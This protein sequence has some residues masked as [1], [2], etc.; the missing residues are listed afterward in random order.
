MAKCCFVLVA[1]FSAIL[2]LGVNDAEAQIYFTPGD[3]P[4]SGNVIAGRSNVP[5][6]NPHFV[7]MNDVGEIFN[8]RIAQVEDQVNNRSVESITLMYVDEPG[9]DVTV[10]QGLDENGNADFNLEAPIFIPANSRHSVLVFANLRSISNN[11]NAAK[12]GDQ[13]RFV[14]RTNEGFSA[15]CGDAEVNFCGGGDVTGNLMVVRKSVPTFSR[16][17]LQDPTLRN[18]LN[19]IYSFSVTASE[20]GDISLALIPIAMGLNCPYVGREG[21]F[22]L[23]E[24]SLLED[25]NVLRKGTD[26]DIKGYQDRGMYQEVNSLTVETENAF[27]RL[28]IRFLNER[29]ISAGQRRVYTLRAVS[30]N[31]AGRGTYSVSAYLGESY[32]WQPFT[33]ML[34]M[35]RQFYSPYL[36]TDRDNWTPEYIWSDFSGTDGNGEHHQYAFGDNG[37]PSTDWINGWGLRSIGSELTTQV[38]YCQRDQGQVERGYL[39]LSNMGYWDGY[40]VNPGQQCRTVDFSASSNVSYQIR[41]FDLEIHRLDAEDLDMDDP[42]CNDQNMIY[43]IYFAQNHGM[44]C[45]P[46]SGRYGISEAENI[47][48]LNSGVKFR[49]NT[50]HQE[51]WFGNEN[52]NWFIS[53]GFH[54]EIPIGI[55]QF[56]I[57]F[58]DQSVY[59]LTNDRWI[60]VEDFYQNDRD[61]GTIVGFELHVVVNSMQLDGDIFTAEDNNLVDVRLTSGSYVGGFQF[62]LRVSP[63]LD[64]MPIEFI[65]P[66]GFQLEVGLEE[67]LI[68]I[69]VFSVDMVYID[70][71]DRVIM[72]MR[73]DGSRLEPQE[74]IHFEIENLRLFDRDGN[75]L[76]CNFAGW[77]AVRGMLGDPNVDFC[78]DVADVMAAIRVIHW[79]SWERFILWSTDVNGDNIWSITD[80]MAIVDLAMHE[81][82]FGVRGQDPEPGPFYNGQINRDDPAFEWGLENAQ[83]IRGLQIDLYGDLQNHEVLLNRDRCEGMTMSQSWHDTLGTMFRRVV[84]WSFGNSIQPGNGPLIII[85]GY[86]GQVRVSEPIIVFGSAN[87]I[88]NNQPKTPLEFKLDAAFPNPFNSSTCIAFAL[89]A[90]GKA[91]MAVYDLSG[92]EVTR[93]VNNTI[94]AGV[95]AVTFDGKDLATG[96]Y[97]LRLETPSG[98][99]SQKLI[100]VK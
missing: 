41:S 15:M 22:T 53:A 83:A 34:D 89:P 59:D 24:F 28:D 61:G 95:Y 5:I 90:C 33:G 46:W 92:R 96:V 85:P 44:G 65:P 9:R 6:L 69:L 93:L 55:Y 42:I 74:E 49:V 27:A 84:I 79:G 2:C 30:S 25:D 51:E 66:D 81:G 54:P 20:A 39:N 70:P 31:M 7:S 3:N 62:D 76:D 71:C 73:V 12:T 48:G 86:E 87:G 75:R 100:L 68:R 94:S 43:A 8:L 17:Q 47:N 77:Q 63:G 57:R 23:S 91:T 14:F 10:T 29:I 32:D 72:G 37:Q 16:V 26:Y 52:A 97:I 67:N 50:I 60:E 4:I 99:R 36:Y 35:G 82:G 40:Y 45:D 56:V 58:D 1:L 88:N 18:G 64:R 11:E 78:I 19:E 21:R 98:V 80:V 38:V 13:L